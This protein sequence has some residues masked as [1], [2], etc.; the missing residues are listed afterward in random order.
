MTSPDSPLWRSVQS[1]FILL[2]LCLAAVL[3]LRAETPGAGVPGVLNVPTAVDVP[4]VL[5]IDLH[6][7]LQPERQQIFVRAIERANRDGYQAILFNLSSPGGFSDST[8]LMVAAMRASRVPIIVWAGWADSRISGEALRLLAEADISLLNSEAF[9]TPLWTDHPHGLT[10][11]KQAAESQRLLA[12]LN[13]A[14]ARHGRSSAANQELSSGRH[15][16]TAQEAIQ[17]GFVDGSAEK[18]SDALR[19]AST[20]SF[21]WEGKTV[22]LNLAGAHVANSQT[23]LQQ[24]LLLTLMNPDLCVLL[25]T[26]GLLLIYLEVNTPG[27]VVPG[28]AGVLLVLLAS[29]ALHMLPLNPWAILLC[30]ISTVLLLMEARFPSHG[31]LAA[32][33]ILALVVGLGTLVNG[34]LPQLQVDWSVAIGAG[35]G[36]GGV[37]ASLIVLGIEARRAKVKTGSDAMLGWL[38]TAQTALSPEG[39]IL[40]RGELWR[41]RLTT[42]DSY[43]AAGERVKV[44]AADGYTLEVTAVPLADIA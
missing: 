30:L 26:L 43:V 28:A 23:K 6:D 11:G 7:T 42:S 39:Q 10:P 18:T 44:L 32:M 12:S 27:A 2:L 16:F 19:V 25:L 40:V 21:R 1:S 9:V 36:F 38:A 34:P 31:V 20:R 15:W 13:E 37:T 5:M 8:D 24:L 29:Y 4:A 14:S 33:G 35:I 3:T 41:A 22:R 17:A